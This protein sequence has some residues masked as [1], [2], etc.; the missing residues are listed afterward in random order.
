MLFPRTGHRSEVGQLAVVLAVRA[1]DEQVAEQAGVLQVV[2]VAP[3]HPAPVARVGHVA[4][5]AAADVRGIVQ[6]R[7]R[8]SVVRARRPRAAGVE[9]VLGLLDGADDVDPVEGHHG[10]VAHYA[11]IAAEEPR[12]VRDDR[13]TARD[14]RVETRELQVGGVPVLGHEAVVLEEIVDRATEL[15]GARLG[16]DA[17]QQPRR[18]DVFGGNAARQ[19]LLLLDDL[20]VEVGTERATDPVGDVDAVDVVEIVAR[21]SRL[22]ADVTVVQARLGRR[23]AGRLRVIG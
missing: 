17:R 8:E 18:A 11:P 16:D 23:V 14:G 19:H 13:A 20:G 1:L 3:L 9:L 7:E 5:A 21:D 12:L 15:V 6:E 10:V 4:V 22:A 2:V